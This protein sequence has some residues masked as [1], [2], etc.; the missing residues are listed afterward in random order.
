[1][2]GVE[3]HS[4]GLPGPIPIEVE[5]VS[6]PDDAAP[7]AQLP[8]MDTGPQLPGPVHVVKSIYHTCWLFEACCA[9]RTW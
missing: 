6:A 8:S 5:G 4:P 2:S 9:V 1:M 7:H 3:G